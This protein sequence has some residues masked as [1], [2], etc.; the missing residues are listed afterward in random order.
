MARPQGEHSGK[1]TRE[2]PFVFE[3]QGDLY[4]DEQRKAWVAT[5]LRNESRQS[6]HPDGLPE[7]VAPSLEFS[8]DVFKEMAYDVAFSYLTGKNTREEVENMHK[9]LASEAGIL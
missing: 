6:D 4:R 1:G 8:L 7:G 9:A 3:R 2:D 5:P